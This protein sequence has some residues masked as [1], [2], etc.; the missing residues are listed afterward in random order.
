[1]PV[2]AVTARMAMAIL[3]VAPLPSPPACAAEGLFTGRELAQLCEG[4]ATAEQLSCVSFLGGVYSAAIALGQLV[5][6]PV[7]CPSELG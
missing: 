4:V 5:G 7:L 6:P 3:A 1:M 2:L